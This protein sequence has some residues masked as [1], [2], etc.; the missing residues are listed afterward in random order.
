MVPIRWVNVDL[1][2]TMPTIQ[3]HHLLPS[4]LP[5]YIQSAC[6]LSDAFPQSAVAELC[7]MDEPTV[8]TLNSGSR[9]VK[10]SPLLV[11]L[12]DA[13]PEQLLALARTEPLVENHTSA[14]LRTNRTYLIW[15]VCEAEAEFEVRLDT[16]DLADFCSHVERELQVVF[17]GPGHAFASRLCM[18]LMEA[19]AFA[20][21]LQAAASSS[22]PNWRPWRVYSEEEMLL[23]EGQLD[24][25]EP[26]IVVPRVF[27][28]K[29]IG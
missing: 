24:A 9:P 3:T 25:A 26:G 20:C 17:V 29:L 2:D 11:W 8:V 4:S 12:P 27:A 19:E 18:D 23:A 21:D 10:D 5:E 28:L 15:R 1:Q 14:D 7:S 16:W 13:R 22:G 6:T